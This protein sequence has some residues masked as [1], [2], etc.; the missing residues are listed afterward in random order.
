MNLLSHK[1]L[2]TCIEKR[3]S[4]FHFTKQIKGFGNIIYAGR[5]IKGPRY[6]CSLT[7][8]NKEEATIEKFS[9]SCRL[10][11]NFFCLV[12]FHLLV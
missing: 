5:T 1:Y 2:L 10:L 4:T 9:S 11:S 7:T 8:K 6:R 3:E 12:F